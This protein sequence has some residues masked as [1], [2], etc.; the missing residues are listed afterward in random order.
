MSVAKTIELS[1]TSRKSFDDAFQQGI[2]RALKTLDNVHGAWVKDQHVV[3]VKNKVT[4]YR[5]RI[6]VTFELKN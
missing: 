5:V 3:I 4:E 6:K 1:S 2:A